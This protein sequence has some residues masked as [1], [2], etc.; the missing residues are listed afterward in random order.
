M[1]PEGPED[2]RRWNPET[3]LLPV[4]DF[5]GARVPDSSGILDWLDEQ[6]PD[7]PFLARDPRIARQ[8]RQLESWIGETFYFYWVR[9]MRERV[10]AEEAA[11]RAAHGAGG[12]LARLGI[13]NRV[14]ELLID[15][16]EKPGERGPEFARRLDDLI[17]FL[18]ARPFLYADEPGRADLTAAAFLR[19]LERNSIPGGERMLEERPALRALLA[20]VRAH[21]G[22]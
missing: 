14:S 4:L 22:H 15:V 1:I 12:E 9:W 20:R 3:G 13:L 11:A 8:Q 2:Y 7:P 17:G 10:L 19:S 21:V 16:A 18:G 5:D 6:F